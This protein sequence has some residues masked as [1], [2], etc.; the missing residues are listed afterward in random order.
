MTILVG[1]TRGKHLLVLF[2]IEHGERLQL[3]CHTGVLSS[4]GVLTYPQGLLV[5][6]LSIAI[7]LPLNINPSQLVQG[8]SYAGMVRV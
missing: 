7:L 8:A 1:N 4:I 6:L 5:Q 2:L 3:S